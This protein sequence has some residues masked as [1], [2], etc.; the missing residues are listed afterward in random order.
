L[1]CASASSRLRA[2]SRAA[3]MIQGDTIVAVATAPGRSAIGVVRLSGSNLSSWIT[4]LLG[5]IPAARLAV[6]ADFHG[7]ENEVIDQ[8]IALY[9]PKPH[10]YT[11]EDVLELQSH[12]GPV[13]LQLLLK[14]CLELGARVAQP[15]EFTQ[16]AYLN[17]KLDL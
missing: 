6:L 1:P 14:R 3:L 8:G 15:G 10:S 16:R 12:G 2:A 17:D 9:F 11:G 4:A 7:A 5:R 13:L